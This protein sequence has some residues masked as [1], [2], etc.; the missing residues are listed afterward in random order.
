V[1]H[2]L[3]KLHKRQRWKIQQIGSNPWSPEV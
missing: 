2:E 1:S 3:E